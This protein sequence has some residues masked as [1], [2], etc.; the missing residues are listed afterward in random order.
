M[1]RY[2]LNT[3]LDEKR[4]A[5]FMWKTSAP[6]RD[7]NFF[8]T[9]PWVYNYFN[10]TNGLYR[11]APF[12][13]RYGKPD[14]NDVYFS[15]TIASDDTIPHMMFLVRKEGW[16]EGS[17]RVP[18]PDDGKKRPFTPPSTPDTILLVNLKEGLNG[19]ANTAHGGAMC[20]LL[21]E[22]LGMTA[23]AHRRTDSEQ[24]FPNLYTAGMNLSFLAPV[25][26]PSVLAI[27][28]WMIKRDGRKWY[29]RAQLVD[30]S[31]TVLMEADSIWLTAKPKSSL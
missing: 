3:D 17:F 26:T 7:L 27:R 19:F 11:A 9:I 12:H 18:K 22:A 13:S 23:E 29:L 1:S 24:K 2:G 16:G 6:E 8:V 21:D 4:L 10:A 5:E 25:P 15:R 31:N 20:S 30:E 14:S 28:S